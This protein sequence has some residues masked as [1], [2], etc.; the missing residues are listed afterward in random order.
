LEPTLKLN[1]KILLITDKK[2]FITLAPD[3]FGQQKENQNLPA[4]P[5]LEALIATQG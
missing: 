2:S 1:T 3:A 5:M 4:K